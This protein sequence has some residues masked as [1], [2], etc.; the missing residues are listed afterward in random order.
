MQACVESGHFCTVGILFAD[1][2]FLEIQLM[3]SKKIMQGCYSFQTQ[4]GQGFLRFYRCKDLILQ[5]FHY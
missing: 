2:F 4:T 1:K 5:A 3:C